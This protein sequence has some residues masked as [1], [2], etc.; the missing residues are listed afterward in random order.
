MPRT[1]ASSR[2]SHPPVTHHD[3][4]ANKKNSLAIGPGPLARLGW[5]FRPLHRSSRAGNGGASRSRPFGNSTTQLTF[6]HRLLPRP[7]TRCARFAQSSARG[8]PFLGDSRGPSAAT[9]EDRPWRHGEAWTAS[10]A[11][12][13]GAAGRRVRLRTWRSRLRQLLSQEDASAHP[14]WGELLPICYSFGRW[15]SIY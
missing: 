4:I 2:L 1:P 8:G 15:V 12:H 10:G 14:C 9:H 3:P 6:S 13:Q 11:P 5:S 7:A